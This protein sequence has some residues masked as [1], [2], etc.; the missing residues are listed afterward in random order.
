MD[1]SAGNDTL[2]GGYGADLYLGGNHIDTADYSDMG[3]AVSVSLD[4]VANDGFYVGNPAAG[5]AEGD[6][7]A[8]SVERVRG[9][10]ATY[11]AD[12]IVGSGKDNVLF[13]FAGNDTLIGFGGNDT[14]YGGDGNDQ[15]DG[16]SG[17]DQL[18]GDAGIDLLM[19]SSGDDL[20]YAGGDG[21]ADVLVGGSG[22]DG[23]TWD[24]IDTLSDAL[25]G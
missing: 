9:T 4:D 20:L 15:I 1:G 16:G 6:N 21:A 25:P 22:S 8:T 12:Y 17:D 18:F 3:N 19:G 2:T 10:N 13:G 11:T 14:I 24:S 5:S 23:G 7:V